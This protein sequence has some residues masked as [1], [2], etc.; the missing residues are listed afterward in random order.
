M[1]GE[2]KDNV[3]VKMGETSSFMHEYKLM[4]E[5]Q[6]PGH[7]LRAFYLDA[8]MESSSLDMMK[9]EELRL[10]TL[11]SFPR[12]NKPDIVS[13]AVAGFYC[14][15]DGDAVTCYCCGLTLRELTA[16]HNPME[17][18]RRMSE[19]C[20][21]ISHNQDVNK[22]YFKRTRCEE[23]ILQA[24]PSCDKKDHQTP[25]KDVK[26]RDECT[27]YQEMGYLEHL[28]RN[29]IA[30]SAVQQGV[31]VKAMC[32]DLDTK[33]ADEENNLKKCYIAQ[34][35]ETTQELG[36]ARS[37]KLSNSQQFVDLGISLRKPVLG[38]ATIPD[39]PID[40]K[41]KHKQKPSI[42]SEEEF[43]SL[44]EIPSSVSLNVPSCLV[45]KV[46]LIGRGTF[47]RCY[48]GINAESGAM[49]AIKEIPFSAQGKDGKPALED[50]RKEFSLLKGLCHPNIIRVLWETCDKDKYHIVME[51]MPGGSVG[52]LL[53]LTENGLKE[54]LI[55]RY[56]KQ[57]L[58]GL[59]YLHSREILHRDI[60]GENLLLTEND[61]DLKIGDFGSATKV[62]CIISGVKEK[63]HV[64][65]VP[66]MAPEGGK[67]KQ[68]YGCR[69]CVECWMLHYSDGYSQTSMECRQI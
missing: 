43:I 22:S 65:T 37:S 2:K 15:S 59:S 29:Q 34:L 6:Q 24:V 36:T 41:E 8:N 14:G 54:S 58:H 48:K 42:Q 3:H 5:P 69:G 10:A 64:G 60:K 13:I 61:L 62:D 35:E 63:S 38:T 57:I 7:N 28:E 17:I 31:K 19:H 12:E 66:L 44:H 49:L 56:T 30:V 16:E 39:C 27:A 25:F 68:L 21:F 53:K 33:Q 46:T 50:T 9:Y 26:D 55:I 45:K 40:L 4:K 1:T 11:R 18:H 52:G 32:N 51:Y 47:G 23:V 67:G 20:R